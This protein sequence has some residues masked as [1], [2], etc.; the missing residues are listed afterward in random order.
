MSDEGR[1]QLRAGLM[2]AIG[3]TLALAATLVTAPS[4]PGAPGASLVVELAD[5]VRVIV[6][7]LLAASA[8]LLLAIQ[9]PRRAPAGDPLA[10]QLYR[11]RSPWALVLSLLPFILLLAVLWYLVW[12]GGPGDDERPIERAIGAIAGLLDLLA[13]TRKAP[14][15]VPLFDM[16]IAALALLAALAVFLLMVVVTFA[17]RLARWWERRPD[18][19]AAEPVAPEPEPADPRAEPDARRAVIGAYRRFERAAAAARLPR[20]AWQTPGEFRR[21][22][23]A[24]LPGPAPSVE[25]LTALFEV[26]RFSQRPLDG[27]SREAACDCLD[28]ITAALAADTARAH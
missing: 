23:V 2:I 1:A 5:P 15:S 27:A 6:V 16:T 13:R 24:R 22:V 19:G 8:L 18:P 10:P 4:T 3:L 17:D 11:A 26:A 9:R 21:M 25:R 12:H 7:V 20:P 28:A 14:T